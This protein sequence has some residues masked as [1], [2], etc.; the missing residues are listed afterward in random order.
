M[1]EQEETLVEVRGL[2]K[3]FAARNRRDAEVRAVSDVDLDVR[4][5]ECLGLV[6][7]SGSGKST[8]ARMV[9]GLLEPT[10][11]TVTIDGIPVDR[12]HKAQYVKRMGA[13]FQDPASSLNPRWTVRQTLERPL[14]VAGVR[15][16]QA[17]ETIREVCGKVGLGEELLDRKP[18]QLSGGQQQRVS[19]ARSVM[20]QPSLL[21]LDE[22]TSALDVSVQAQTLNELLDLQESSGL[23]YL[24]ITHNLS[25][26]R[27]MA[28]RVA[29]MYAG[30]LVEVGPALDVCDGGLHPYTRSLVAS[31]PALN[32][33][34]RHDEKGTT[35][36]TVEDLSVTQGC[37]FAP[38]CPFATEACR[39]QAPRLR[40]V[41]P[42][43]LVACHRTEDAGE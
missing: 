32:P 19:V 28:H 5:G 24:F 40:E 4:R 1:S 42:G 22:P 11:G 8:L 18:A 20:L 30:C 33:A 34:D 7:E 38:R 13:V 25:V 6:G 2:T 14:E 31:V 36:E 41:R 21:V 37:R 43:H 16:D 17:R 29:V 3:V 26:V 15:G 10:S 9:L 39:F 12:A 23:T 35:V 27:Y